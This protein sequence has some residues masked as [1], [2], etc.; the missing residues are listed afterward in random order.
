MIIGINALGP[1]SKDTGG[2]TYLTNFSRILADW[3]G[4]EKFI[5]FV[6]RGEEGILHRGPNLHFSFIPFSARNSYFR[7]FAENILLPIAIRRHGINLMYFPGNFAPWFCPVPYGLALRSMLIYHESGRTVDRQRQWYR[8]YFYPRSA[9]NAIVVVTPSH[10]TKTEIVRWLH[11][12]DDHISVI[13][14]GVDASLFSV[15][16]SPE[17]SQSVMAKYRLR[18][19]YYLYVSG[20]W[21]YKNQDKLILAFDKLVRTKYIPH[22]LVLVG[23]GMNLFESFY[24]R[25]QNL[26]TDLGLRDRIHFIEFMPH[27]ELR[28]VYALA[29][30]FAFPSLVE[31][32]GNPLFEAF[33]S[34]VPVVC[35][36]THGFQGMVGDS[37]L[38]FDP[39]NVDEFS[40]CLYR[41]STD[42]ELRKQMIQ[43]GLKIVQN[44]TWEHCVAHTVRVLIRAFN[45]K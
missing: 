19:P 15:S 11:V 31:S 40:E 23:R 20:L 9:N 28:T 1:I 38:F 33:A 39:A 21:E 8:K 34:S 27:Q 45:S 29:D 22:D 13:S 6:S 24:G 3:T 36:N 5:F 16:A 41:A 12:P 25:L 42:M 10:H 43:R 7:L 26:V 2:R 14:H 4:P 37:A 17:E 18:Q 32:F 44:L 35:S 30:V